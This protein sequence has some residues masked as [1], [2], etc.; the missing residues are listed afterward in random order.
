M[1]QESDFFKSRKT[2]L[3]L[4]VVMILF[5][6]INTQI[7]VFGQKND[8]KP[9]KGKDTTT[10]ETIAPLAAMSSGSPLNHC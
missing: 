7:P 2:R 10:V 3:I 1:K 5:L 4:S 8:T 6:G 9:P